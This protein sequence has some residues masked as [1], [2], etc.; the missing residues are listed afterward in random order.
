MNITKYSA[1]FSMAILLSGAL[2]TA[3]SFFIANA[4]ALEDNKYKKIK[5]KKLKCNNIN[6]NI[7][8]EE[9]IHTENNGPFCFNNNLT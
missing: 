6:V 3:F 9:I 4:E 5:V 8:G 1:M 7:D 2:A